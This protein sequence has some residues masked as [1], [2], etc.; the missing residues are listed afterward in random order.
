MTEMKEPRIEMRGSWLSKTVQSIFNELTTTHTV[1][2][3][4]T[5]ITG[6]AADGDMSTGVAGRGI[7]L[8]TFSCRI[9]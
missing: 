6:S 2:A 4:Q 7:A 1:S 5:F 3:V 8:H 9:Y